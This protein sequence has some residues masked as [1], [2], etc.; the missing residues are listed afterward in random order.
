MSCQGVEEDL[1]LGESRGVHV[2]ETGLRVIGVDRSL[3][4]EH[5]GWVLGTFRSLLDFFISPWRR[6]RVW[7]S[8]RQGGGGGIF[9]P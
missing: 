6:R 2:G 1:G 3:W 5:Y 7:C 9:L 4:G 8:V